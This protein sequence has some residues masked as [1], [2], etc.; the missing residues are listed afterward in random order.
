MSQIDY[1]GIAVS[2]VY[3]LPRL[4]KQNMSLL[5]MRELSLVLFEEK[6][7]QQETSINR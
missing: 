6:I 4:G 1:K 5:N 3:C 2:S 7:Y